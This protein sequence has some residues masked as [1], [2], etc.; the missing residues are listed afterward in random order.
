MDPLPIACDLVAVPSVSAQSN[1]PV[2]DVVEALLRRLEFTVERQEFTDP[3][4]TPQVNVLGR[5]GP[6]GMGLAYF[7]HT[8]VVP[9][10]TWTC[11]HGPF[12]PTVR[13]GRLY[14]RGSCDMK[15]SIAAFLAAAARVPTSELT[16]PLYVVCTADEEIGY[17]GAN[18]VVA[19]STIYREIVDSRARGL[20]G[21][22][23]ELEV[24]YAHKGGCGFVVTSRGR[25]AHT[26][27]RE[28]VNANWAMIPFL[29][30]MHDIH[31]ETQSDPTWLNAEFDPPEIS[32]NLFVSDHDPVINMTAPE[33][34]CRVGFRPMPGQ[35]PQRLLDRAQKKAAECGLEFRMLWN[36]SPLYTNPRSDLI[37][38]VLKLAGKSTP[39]TVAFGTDGSC[40]GEVQELVVFGPGSVKQAHTDDEWLELDQLHSGAN[41]YERLIRHWCTR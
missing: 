10:A 28:G 36:S 13:D 5:K 9:A 22:P 11:S 21:E 27:T 17:H 18:Y 37:Q 30:E 3:A 1:G 26:S 32:L 35:D 6:D 16:A 31:R 15:G 33:T 25:A 40:F 41:L 38:D 39:R 14:G 19:H 12:T 23:T 4:G 8:D 34:V 29:Q 7:G 20:I 2:S 24:V